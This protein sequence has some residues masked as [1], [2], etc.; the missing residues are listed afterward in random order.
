MSGAIRLQPLSGKTLGEALP[1]LA[2]LRIEVFRDFPYLYA[3][4][5][6]Y[7]QTY[8]E[9]YAE[10]KDAF[11]IAAQTAG[12]EIVGCATGS[13]LTDHHDDFVAPL[14]QAGHDPS[15]VFY[16]GESVLLPS[17][18][19]H[20]LGHAF[21]DAREA[22]ARERGYAMACFCAV[23]RPADHPKRPKGYSP[24]DSFWGRR[25][26][27]KLPGVSAGFNWPE[28]LGGPDLSHRM[29]YWMRAL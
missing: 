22:H 18:R 13:A 6:A 28:T 17:F 15:E 26:Y 1:A 19:G 8:L 3:G 25:G 11:I 9:T 29:N 23:E 21:F 20:G 10:A 12:G 24:L 4:T 2:Q 27:E 16:F 5:A 14:A 7:E